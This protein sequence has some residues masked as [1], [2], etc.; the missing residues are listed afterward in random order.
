MQ[1]EPITTRSAPRNNRRILATTLV[2]AAC[3]CSLRAQDAESLARL[4]PADVGLFVEARGADDLLVPLT[5]EQVWIT[6]AE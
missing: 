4:V 2:V 3:V 5:E 1:S 6:L